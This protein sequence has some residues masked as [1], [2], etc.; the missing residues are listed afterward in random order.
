MTEGDNRRFP[1]WMVFLQGLAVGLA[2]FTVADLSLSR[3]LDPGSHDMMLAQ[4]LGLVYTPVV[5]AWLG[6][7]Q[8]SRRRAVVGALA[9]LAVG[10]VYYLLCT[11]RDFFAIMVGFPT[12]LGG[13]LAGLVGSNR[14][15]GVAAFFGRLARGLVAGLV[16]GFV[17][18]FLLNF[19]LN[20][21]V[22]PASLFAAYGSNMWKGGLPAMAISSALFLVL[23]RWAVGLVRLRIEHA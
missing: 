17:Y 6:W 16:L 18:M 2:A 1:T 19:I 9:G 15:Q 23:L 8:R 12:L 3:D 10:T 11:S 7:L 20:T 14:S 5:G 13:G 21:F 22:T 4:R